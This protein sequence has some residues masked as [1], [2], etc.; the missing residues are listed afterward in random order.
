VILQYFLK[1][2]LHIHTTLAP[3]VFVKYHEMSKLP[4]NFVALGD[5][6]MRSSPVYG[7]GVTKGMVEAVTLAG[8]LDKIVTKGQK[9]IPSGFGLEVMKSTFNRVG[10]LW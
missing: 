6:A 8:F 10:W 9:G 1:L 2:N 3:S 5:S 4:S 7:L